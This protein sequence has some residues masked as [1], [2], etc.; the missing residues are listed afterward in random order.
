M[1]RCFRGNK[2]A[3]ERELTTVRF[4]ALQTHLNMRIPVRSQTYE[5]NPR[6]DLE[7]LFGLRSECLVDKTSSIEPAGV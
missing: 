2:T 3:G 6:H 7:F 5:R 4:I 1:C